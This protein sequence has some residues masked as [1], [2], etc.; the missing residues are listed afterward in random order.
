[1][2]LIK[3]TECGHMVSDKA[4]VCSKCGCP[5]DNQ[6]NGL[7]VNI[8]KQN[9]SGRKWIVAVLSIIVLIAAVAIVFYV[10]SSEASNDDSEM[11]APQITAEADGFIVLDQ[12]PTQ[13]PTIRFVLE[14]EGSILKAKVYKNDMLLQILEGEDEY[15]ALATDIVDINDPKNVHFMDINFD[16]YV[17]IFIGRSMSRTKSSAFLW[18]PT[19]ESFQQ[20]AKEEMFQNIILEPSSKSLYQGGSGSWC[21]SGFSRY[22]WYYYS[23]EE[24]ETLEVVSDASQYEDY[25][26]THEYTVKTKEGEIVSETDNISELP[27][28]WRAV[29][30]RYKEINME[31]TD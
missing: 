23:V 4:T 1:M 24:L 11:M 20:V 19:S 31:I 25:N 16:G 30:E 28:K 26:V 7:N 6:S 21:Y 17:D 8:H 5:I 13:Y 14:G 27:E 22:K 9:G 12:C 10:F 2:A 15:D 18:N 29:Y 3:C